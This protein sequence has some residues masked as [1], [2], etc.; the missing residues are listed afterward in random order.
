MFYGAYKRAYA[1]GN[2]VHVKQEIDPQQKEISIV[3][4]T[5]KPGQKVDIKVEY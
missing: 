4:I 2:L 3:E 5:V 1:N